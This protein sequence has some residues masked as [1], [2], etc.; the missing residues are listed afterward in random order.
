M[1]QWKWQMLAQNNLAVRKSIVKLSQSLPRL[2]CWRQSG[3]ADEWLAIK[4]VSPPAVAQHRPSHA[5]RVP[6]A[7]SCSLAGFAVKLVSPT[8]EQVSYAA[9]NELR[10]LLEYGRDATSPCSWLEDMYGTMLI[11][12]TAT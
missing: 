2:L 1:A 9:G 8:I 3:E 12:G 5:T 6:Y 4:R 10:F 11:V 7:G